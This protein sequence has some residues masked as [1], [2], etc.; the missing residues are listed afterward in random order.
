MSQ[1]YWDTMVMVFK[2]PDK[3][4]PRVMKVTGCKRLL[5]GF[6]AVL[7]KYPDAEFISFNGYQYKTNAN[8][9]RHTGSRSL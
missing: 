3:G 2:I 1:F 9:C 7:E 5:D 8:Q 6:S 4:R